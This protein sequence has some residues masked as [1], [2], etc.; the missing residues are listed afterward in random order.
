MADHREVM[1]E[2]LYLK[3][4]GTERLRKGASGRL[5]YLL[6]TGWRETDRW[7]SADY[8]LVRVERTGVVPRMTRLPKPPPPQPRPPRRNFG[9]GQQGGPPRRP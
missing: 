3:E 8:I 4:P 1:H 2:R 7:L 5:R 9:P 6:S